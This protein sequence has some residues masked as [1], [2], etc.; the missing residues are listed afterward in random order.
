MKC[1]GV[2]AGRE[3]VDFRAALARL[4]EVEPGAALVDLEIRPEEVAEPE[5]EI[6]K[7][8]NPLQVS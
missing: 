4:K 2:D 7:L 3:L 1:I 8:D 5:R 6:E